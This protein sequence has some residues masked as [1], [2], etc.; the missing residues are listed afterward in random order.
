MEDPSGLA[1]EA[2]LGSNLAIVRKSPELRGG[3]IVEDLE[4]QE[5]PESGKRDVLGIELLG[6]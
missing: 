6:E 5:E 1:R 3:G 2:Q 4:R